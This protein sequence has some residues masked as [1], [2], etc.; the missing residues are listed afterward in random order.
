ME[1][2]ELNTKT[3]SEEAL[4]YLQKQLYKSEELPYLFSSDGD[5]EFL[6]SSFG[7]FNNNIPVAFA[8]I[9]NNPNLEYNS[10]KT[11]CIGNYECIDSEFVSNLLFEGVIEYL[12][13]KSFEFLVGPMNGSTWYNYRFKVD[14]DSPNFFLEPYHKNY[15]SLQFLNT[16]FYAVSKYI[17]AVDND[18]NY[19]SEALNKVKQSLIASGVQFRSID[20][21]NIE[22]DLKGV[23]ELTLESFTK[24]SFYVPLSWNKFWKKNEAMVSKIDPNFFLV[25]IHNN[26]IVAYLFAIENYFNFEEKQVVLKTLAAKSDALYRGTGFVLLDQLNTYLKNS[27]YNSLI[28]AFMY[29]DNN[30]IRMSNKYS[31]D[32]YSKYSLYGMDL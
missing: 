10:L 31:Q 29:E 2:R 32:I 8:R 18:L 28:H 14:I 22:T 15:Y 26:F 20:I 1:F 23:Y 25:A 9:Y 7:V 6:D 11:A 27:G 4:S 3:E 21:N 12:R 13:N 17:S 16:G 5:K 19:K 24:N 30:V